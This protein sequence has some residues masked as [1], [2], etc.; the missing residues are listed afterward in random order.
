MIVMNQLN[1]LLGWT[2]A[3][4]GSKVA[5]QRRF[6]L[7]LN[8]LQPDIPFPIIKVAGTNGKGSVSAML[9]ACLTEAGKKVGL[10]TSP[11]LLSPV[12]RFRI[13]YQEISEN[14]LDAQ[15][16][17]VKEWLHDWVDQN[18]S[19]YTPSFF[20]SLIVIALRYFK[21]E[22]VDIAVFEAGVGGEN[23]AVSLLPDFCAVLTNIGLDH[24]AQLGSTLEAIATD[25]AGI[26]RS[27]TLVLNSQID[28]K[29]KSIIQKRAKE[30][31][32]H[33]LASDN[34]I[35][36]AQEAGKIRVLTEQGSV[37]L[38]PALKGSYQRE[39]INLVLSTYRFLLENGHL[40]SWEGIIGLEKAY[41]PGRF[42]PLGESPRWLIDAAH[43][44]S[45]LM[46]LSSAL[47]K[48]SKKEHRILVYGNSEEKDYPELLKIVPSLAGRVY[49]VDDF[50]KAVPRTK[51]ISY[52]DP[53][54]RILEPG[55]LTLALADAQ[56]HFP[57]HIIIITGS[58]FM[59]GKARKWILQHGLD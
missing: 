50:Y 5:M 52:L 33:V 44:E 36:P 40:S 47:D 6:G 49:L 28:E 57:N 13:N 32:V 7:L 24:H 8:D 54:I 58:I 4:V 53:K 20:E 59:I 48:I 45:G 27:G 1:D 55:I 29:L 38:L 11:H 16:Q 3:R 10:F 2:Q 43:N 42:E 35:H 30:N 37:E 23:D 9:A 12:E 46:A 15:A 14:E 21:Q 17:Y 19:A 39:N 18:G 22:N 31:N 41:W 26:A 51:L 25:K 34:W 56:K